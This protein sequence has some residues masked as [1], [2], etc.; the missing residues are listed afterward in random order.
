MKLY[1]FRRMTYGVSLLAL[2][3]I[4][5]CV[6]LTLDAIPGSFAGLVWSLIVFGV[7]D[8][9]SKYPVLST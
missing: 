9:Q 6:Q 1:K 7:Q 2:I 8:V 3:F 4:S 5:V